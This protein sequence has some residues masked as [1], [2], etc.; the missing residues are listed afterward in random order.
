M[1]IPRQIPWTS[2]LP[3]LPAFSPSSFSPIRS[4]TLSPSTCAPRS[5]LRNVATPSAAFIDA[6][7][8]G[9]L[10]RVRTLASPS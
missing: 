5:D 2:A 9:D 6:L 8:A 4:T 1:F 10:S 7:F 3:C